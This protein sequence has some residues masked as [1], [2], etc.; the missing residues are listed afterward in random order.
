MSYGDNGECIGEL[1][2]HENEGLQAMFTMMN[3]ARINV[4]QPGRAD[5]RTRDAAGV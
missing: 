4:G 2:G 1:V 3:Q 5:R